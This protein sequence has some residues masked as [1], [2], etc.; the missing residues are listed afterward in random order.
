MNEASIS[1]FGVGLLTARC[2]RVTLGFGA[3]NLAAEILERAGGNREMLSVHRGR[4]W[5]DYR[6]HRDCFPLQRDGRDSYIVISSMAYLL[7]DT[8]HLLLRVDSVESDVHLLLVITHEEWARAVVGAPRV[9]DEFRPVPVGLDLFTGGQV[10][11]IG[12]STPTEIVAN[13]VGSR[14][15]P[16]LFGAAVG[17][18]ALPI[19]LLV[20]SGE[21]P[22]QM[23]MAGTMLGGAVAGGVAGF[24]LLKLRRAGRPTLFAKGLVGVVMLMGAVSLLCCILVNGATF[25]RRCV[26]AGHAG[27][28]DAALADWR[29]WLV[30]P[31]VAEMVSCGLLMMTS[32]Q[33]RRWRKKGIELAWGLA[34][35]QR[36]E[37]IW[38]L[39][40][41]IPIMTAARLAPRVAAN[42][43]LLGIL[44]GLIWCGIVYVLRAV[45]V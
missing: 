19:L 8:H 16:T 18:V 22:S 42:R 23:M 26:A 30:V 5:I 39:H 12:Y 13:G 37:R 28:F 3:L 45:R 11:F 7:R 14:L 21:E 38:L 33:M 31:L 29:I 40:H 20:L 10:V 34:L 25:V 6:G 41:A 4:L 24:G 44:N 43:W 27:G 17:T 35:V 36:C 1:E 32:A 9:P 2:I 15:I